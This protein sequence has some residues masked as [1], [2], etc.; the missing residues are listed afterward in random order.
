MRSGP[1]GVLG[2]SHSLLPPSGS[3]GSPTVSHG[4]GTEPQLP[5]HTLVKSGPGSES[6][7]RG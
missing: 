5:G 6:A 1:S 2:P 4:A 3:E 7:T